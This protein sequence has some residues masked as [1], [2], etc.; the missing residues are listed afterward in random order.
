MGNVKSD[1]I[2]TDT[3]RPKIHDR[4]ALE[5]DSI[6]LHPLVSWRSVIAGLLIAFLCM[7]ILMSLGLA[8]GGVSLSNMGTDASNAGRASGIWFLIASLISVFAGSYYAARISKFHTHRIG[9]A[10]GLVITSLFFGLFMWQGIS[11]IGWAGNKMTGAVSGAA[12]TMGQASDN[13]VVSGVVEDAIGDLNLKSSPQTV[14]SGVVTRLLRGDHEGAKNYLAMQAGVTPQEADRRIADLRGRVDTA[15]IQV[16]ATAAKAMQ[17]AGLMIFATLVLGCVAAI[18]GG[19]LGS[20]ANLRRPLT[21]DELE[22][23]SHF[24][25]ATV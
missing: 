22:A 11:A 12:S 6:S 20:R 18:G 17:G 19:A 8:I 13:P 7:A 25:T 15:M 9:S 4:A 2:R 23:V 10:Q 14:V 16:R 24:E 5:S 1:D 3:T 21:R